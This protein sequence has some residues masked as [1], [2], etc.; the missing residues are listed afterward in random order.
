MVYGLNVKPTHGYYVEVDALD[1]DLS[2]IEIADKTPDGGLPL[3]RSY[4]FS[5]G[6]SVIPDHMPTKTQWGDRHGHQFRTST[7]AWCL[8]SL[9]QR[10]GCSKAVNQTP[11]SSC[12][13]PIST[14]KAS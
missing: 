8:M 3:N 1:G 7:T 5:A 6:R 12:P 13:S 2:I 9:M 11:T 14:D 4:T 10:E